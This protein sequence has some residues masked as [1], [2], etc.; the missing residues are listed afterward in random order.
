MKDANPARVT[1][2]FI[3]FQ[4]RPG[5]VDWFDDAGWEQIVDNFRFAAYAAEASGMKGMIFD[6]EPY[7]DGFAQFEYLLQ[8]GFGA[9]DFDAYAAKARQRGRQTMRAMQA[10]YPDITILSLFLNSYVIVP[11]Y[12]SEPAFGLD[13]PKLS[14]VHNP[15]A[16][17]PYFLDGWL[18]VANEGVTIVDGNERAYYYNSPLE[19]DTI[20][21]LIEDEGAELV[22]PRN[23]DKYRRQVQVGSTV[24]LDAYEESFP[25]QFQPD[26]PEGTSW[27]E[28]FG[29]NLADALRT[30]DE[31]VWLYAEG[32]RLWSEASA[33]GPDVR[34]WSEVLPFTVEALAAER[35]R[36]RATPPGTEAA[37][38]ATLG[39][40]DRVTAY[41]RERWRAAVADGS[42]GELNRARNASFDT[43]VDGWG[44]FDDAA[45]R[46]DGRLSWQA[47]GTGGEGGALAIDGARAGSSFQSYDVTPGEVIWVQ[48]EVSRTGWSEPSVGVG[49]RGPDE[50][51]GSVGRF[52]RYRQSEYFLP[53][54]TPV[55]SRGDT[56]SAWTR[57]EGAAV[58]PPTATKLVLA[59]HADAQ[60]DARD[61]ASF[62]DVVVFGAGNAADVPAGTPAPVPAPTGTSRTRRR[63][64]PGQSRLRRRSRRVDVNTAAS[65][66]LVSD[67]ANGDGAAV[68]IEA[69][70]S[71]VVQT[72]PVRP[73]QRYAVSASGRVEGA[74]DRGFVGVLFRGADGR[75]V[76]GAFD[77]AKVVSPVWARYAV[78]GTVPPAAVEIGVF[79]WKEDAAGTLLADDFSLLLE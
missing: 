54:W 75:N 57:I 69:A 37:V 51:D 15:Y 79:A 39:E 29:Q 7:V 34:P 20:A 62:D 73:G 77:S 55:A 16:L 2:N 78:E 1:N 72:V 71:G 38:E 76:A 41:A 63:R 56:P 60:R 3:R 47:A 6:P 10:E 66:S 49:F 11:R 74:A 40:R 22:S 21:S 13:D 45:R 32:G 28:L 5:S 36:R 19:F 12:R 64:P 30:T 61:R 42:A 25:D 70:N 44:Y 53:A 35:G 67:D 27:A 14:L 65:P 8:T 52:L 9:R 59:L 17:L 46:S 50:A 48:A 4:S 33:R 24:F 31:Y 58:A 23:R 68:A 18:D 43:G 26:L